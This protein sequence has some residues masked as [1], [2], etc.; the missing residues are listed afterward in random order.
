MKLKNKNKI[1]K[2]FFFLII[3]SFFSKF[4][5]FNFNNEINVKNNY[6]IDKKNNFDIVE[7]ELGVGHSSILLDNGN[8][9]N[10]LYM[11]GRNDYGQVG[12][13]TNDHKYRP[14]PIDVDGDGIIGNEKILD[15]DLGFITSAA[16]L[17][18]GNGTQTL[19]T[20]GSNLNGQLGINSDLGMQKKTPTAIDVN[21][22]G[23]I[24]NENIINLNLSYSNIGVLIDTDNDISNGGEEIWL[25]GDNQYG[26]IFSSLDKKIFIPKIVSAPE[27]IIRKVDVF[28]FS[29]MNTFWALDNG[30]DGTK[31]IFG[32]GQNQYGQL[33][34]RQTGSIPHNATSIDVDGSGKVGDEIL[35]EINVGAFASVSAV[36]ENDDL[37]ATQSLY[38]WGNNYS[39]Q[40]GDG[41]DDNTYEPILVDIDGDGE[42]GEEKIFK[43]FTSWYH[44]AVIL[45]N[46]DIDNTYTYYSWG[47]NDYGQI[48]DGTIK[49]RNIPTPIDI[50]GDGT[51]GNEKIVDANLGWFNSSIILEDSS[52]KKQTYIWG[53]NDFGQV[54]DGT[55]ELK[56]VPT[57]LVVVDY[58][59]FF[60]IEK[61]QNSV[62]F[63][64]ST[65]LK[66]SFFQKN[67]LSIFDGKQ[68]K[69]KTS[70]DNILDLY[71]INDL[72]PGKNYFFKKI[73]F[74]NG[75]TNYDISNFFNVLTD[76]QINNIF[77]WNTTSTTAEIYLD[78]I[79]TNFGMF[80]E[81]ER[82]IQIDYSIV[83]SKIEES[84]EVV[85]SKN[86]LLNFSNLTP[87]TTYKIS[88]IS[89]NKNEDGSF[90][91]FVDINENNEISTP[92]EGLYFVDI[93]NTF[94]I[95]DS[96]IDSNS[97]SFFIEVSDY[98]NIFDDYEFVFLFFENSKGGESPVLAY[99][100]SP[101]Q[102]GNDI[103]EFEVR[104]L[105]SDT[106]Y[107]F[108]GI[109]IDRIMSQDDSGS[110]E[111]FIESKIVVTDIDSKKSYYYLFLILFLSVLLTF[112]LLL[113]VFKSINSYKEIFS[114]L[115]Q[116]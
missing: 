90:K 77:D 26:G 57:L 6:K 1:F 99:K 65:N 13:G 38:T 5:L 68:N 86:G 24:G 16:L 32:R 52:N 25:W 101:N 73:S 48:G 100:T 105:S 98:S 87:Y 66:L 97:F 108:V 85:I 33:G 54:G 71:T 44:S 51:I 64:L 36:L 2:L 41:T 7:T 103:Y 56:I 9:T 82:T 47:Q 15:V 21:V 92:S 89:Y 11:W 114:Q 62:V 12:D 14:T 79:S 63:E 95:I 107:E 42:Y 49:D 3:F 22:D 29:M 104:N 46:D 78:I 10:T 84:I 45:D 31:T 39:S 113:F 19:Y 83:P 109:S 115:D 94:K 61:N 55:T 40:L 110:N 59:N 30:D 106:T 4:F 93:D 43:N 8:G 74:D 18:N 91:Y 112:I 37:G 35:K 20:W 53:Y 96:S 58:F 70:Y 67:N 72:E 88:K 75:N 81:E 34:F 111:S 102:A 76:Y 23:K 28:K 80:S 69:Y 60:I 116:L 17:D 27:S 50:D